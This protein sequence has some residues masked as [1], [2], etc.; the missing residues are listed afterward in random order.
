MCVCALQLCL[1]LC[2]P[3][4]CS[5]PGSPAHG[6]FQARI[7]GV[8]FHALLQG[9][10]QTQGSNLS[11]GGLLYWQVGSLP[12]LPHGLTQNKFVSCSLQC[13]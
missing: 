8:G 7:H 13:H 6:I 2:S 12:S 10:F 3:M 1:T 5:P 4:D 9:I 11:L